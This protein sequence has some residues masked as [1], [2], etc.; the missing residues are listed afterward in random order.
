MCEKLGEILLDVAAAVVL[1]Y[2]D[3]AHPG[4]G[5]RRS[6]SSSQTIIPPRR[7]HALIRRRQPGGKREREKS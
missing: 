5:R 6:W 1:L 3:S 2:A 4:L 7:G